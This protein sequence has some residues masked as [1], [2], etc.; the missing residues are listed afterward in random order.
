MAQVTH[1]CVFHNYTLQCDLKLP[2]KDKGFAFLSK[3][4]LSHS[5]R[6]CAKFQYWYL[7]GVTEVAW[8]TRERR[9]LESSQQTYAGS[10]ERTRV[11][12]VTSF[13]WNKWK[14]GSRNTIWTGSF[15]VRL[16]LVGENMWNN[17]GTLFLSPS[18]LNC[19]HYCWFD[20]EQRWGWEGQAGVWWGA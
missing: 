17:A 18:V 15:Y 16:R 3:E 5:A 13:K 10:T 7:G 9:I 6:P 2:V 1:I 20:Y 12:R 11:M 8:V 19:R 14:L 4:N